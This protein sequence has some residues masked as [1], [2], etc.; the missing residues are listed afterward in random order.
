MDTATKRSVQPEGR[1]VPNVILGFSV[2][3]PATCEGGQVDQKAGK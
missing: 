1:Y 3:V 2:Y